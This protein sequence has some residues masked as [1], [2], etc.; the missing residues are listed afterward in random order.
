M[1]VPIWGILQRGELL[2]GGSGGGMSLL[3]GAPQRE[4]AFWGG[5]CA[6]YMG[7]CVPQIWGLRLGVSYEGRLH[8]GGIQRGAPHMRGLHL[9]V[10]LQQTAPCP[11][12]GR[13]P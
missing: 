7:G 5:G 8:S 9:G 13:P 10:P 3:W 2:F 11:P 12:G 4:S 1:G 6:P